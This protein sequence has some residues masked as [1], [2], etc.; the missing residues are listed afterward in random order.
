MTITG[1]LEF[2]DIEGGTW[3][4]RT[5]DGSWV[6][7]GHIPHHLHDT[8]VEV[9]GESSGGMGFHMAGRGLHVTAIRPAPRPSA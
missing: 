8:E 6:L 4:L 7:H 3:V 9:E 5:T 1:R 2:L